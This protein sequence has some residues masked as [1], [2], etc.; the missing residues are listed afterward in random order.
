MGTGRGTPFDHRHQAPPPSRRRTGG[1]G[2]PIAH[3]PGTVTAGYEIEPGKYSSEVH[4]LTGERY[5]FEKN[6]L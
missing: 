3:I 6:I 5:D 4:D 2:P 1:D